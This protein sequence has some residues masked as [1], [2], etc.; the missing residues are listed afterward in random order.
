VAEMIVTGRLHFRDLPALIHA[1]RSAPKKQALQ[2]CCLL[3]NA[4]A[5]AQRS[6]N[7][8]RGWCDNDR[9]P[10]GETGGRIPIVGRCGRGITPS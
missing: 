1:H 10:D 7:T 2:G 5:H 6:A 9:E 8:R 4:Y 3:P